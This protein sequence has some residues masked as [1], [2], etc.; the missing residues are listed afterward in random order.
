M[1][2]R[3]VEI[4]G[5][6]SVLRKQTLSLIN[7]DES[8]LNFHLK[9][10]GLKELREDDIYCSGCK[11]EDTTIKPGDKLLNKKQKK[12]FISV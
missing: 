11:R 12:C 9:C 3:N 4:V 1:M 10:I 7:C 5:V 6:K 2:L 8:Q